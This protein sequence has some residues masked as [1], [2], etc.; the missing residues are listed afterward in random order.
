MTLSDQAQFHPRRFLLPLVDRLPG[1]GSHVFE[2]TH[3]LVTTHLPILD[4]GLYFAKAHPSRAYVV[5][6]AI[7]PVQAPQGMFITASQPTRSIRTAHDGDRL[8]LLVGGEGHK[9]GEGSSEERYATLERFGRERFGVEDVAYRWSTHDFFTLDRVPYVGRLRRGSDRI[10]VATVYGSWGMTNGTAAAHVLADAVLGRQNRWSELYDAHRLTVRASATSFVKENANV[11]RHFVG[12]RLRKSPHEPEASLAPREGRLLE[13]DGRRVA[14]YRDEA[15]TMHRLSPAC[16]HLGCTVAWNDAE[17]TWDCP[18][19]GSR[20]D[21]R[22]SVIEGP[23]VRN[24]RR[25]EP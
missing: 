24:L 3:V 21:G 22:G 16:T 9:P 23:A 4:R 2:H 12:D 19:H 7:D 14:A 15:G 13:M 5:A 10:L 11:A 8:L 1:D 17:R 6:F 20:F 18:C 25:L